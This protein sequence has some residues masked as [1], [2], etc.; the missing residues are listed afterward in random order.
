MKLR[1]KAISI[2]YLSYN[3]C[4]FHLNGF[5]EKMIDVVVGIVLAVWGLHGGMN[6]LTWTSHFIFFYFYFFLRPHILTSIFSYQLGF[7]LLFGWFNRK[8]IEFS[9]SRLGNWH[10]WEFS[11]SYFSLLSIPHLTSQYF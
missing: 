5:T 11:L 7:L 10:Y 8:K 2:T 6:S 9:L 4:A 1:N 3:N